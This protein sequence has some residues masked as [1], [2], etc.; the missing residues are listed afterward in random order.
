MKQGI[1]P[2]LQD[3]S[4]RY[5]EIGRDCADLKVRDELQRLGLD[6]SNRAYDLAAAFTVRDKGRPRGER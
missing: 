5:T 6:I 4:I 2:Y 1:I 3:L